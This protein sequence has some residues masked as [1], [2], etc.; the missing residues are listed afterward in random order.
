MHRDD[1]LFQHFVGSSPS[2]CQ[3]AT[4]LGRLAQALKAH[5]H[6][7]EM[8]VPESEERLRWSL[9]RFLG[10]AAKKAWPAHLVIVIDG[11][12]ALRSD[13]ASGDHGRVPS[14]HW[15]PTELPGN[16]RLVLAASAFVASPRAGGARRAIFDK[17]DE[18]GD[19][20]EGPGGAVA[21][22]E[23]RLQQTLVPEEEED[24][25]EEGDGQQ[26]SVS[27]G[28]TGSGGG[29]GNWGGR[30]VT[31]LRRRGNPF[32]VMEP[33]TAVARGRIVDEFLQRCEAEQAA[34][35]SGD[36]E[37]HKTREC[38]TLTPEQRDRII[39]APATRR[40]LFLRMLLYALK[41]GV[42]LSAHHSMT[43]DHQLDRYL[44]TAAAADGGGGGGGGKQQQQD[45]ASAK[46]LIS[47]ILDLSQQYV[48]G[49]GGGSPQVQG[50]LPRV[51]SAVYASRDGLSDE[52]L[53]GLVE[54]GM[55]QRLAVPL[56]AV[57]T[58]LNDMTILVKGLR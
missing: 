2:S 1:F 12:D 52:E 9:A 23:Q 40:P 37:L 11:I 39:R 58:V 27:I 41:L 26:R 13:A 47:E 4:L 29:R 10:A 28:G 20:K 35:A 57:V 43:L 46:G 48:E 33:L 21:G 32:L 45:D 31:E 6:L 8:A 54:L 56:D 17:E 36:G 30:I 49:S 24:E 55:R 15:L 25:D 51:L 7:R 14:L 3:L 22:R 53:R 50:L 19:G 38:L 42:A 5:Y 44:A 34:S 16:V 18:K